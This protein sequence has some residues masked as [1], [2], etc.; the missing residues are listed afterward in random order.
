MTKKEYLDWVA[1]IKCKLPAF[2]KSMQGSKRKGF[3][4]YSYSGDLYGENIKW[5]LGNSVF[6][7]KIYYSLNYTPDNL[8]E[9]ISFIKSF[10]QTNGEFFDPIVKFT[11]FPMRLY[12]SIK[13]RD[14]NRL[15]H[16]LIRMAESRQSISALRL[17]NHL[18]SYEYINY[19]NTSKSIKQFI[20]SLNWSIPWG[21]GAQISGLLF[22]LAASS[23]KNRVEL[24]DEVIKIVNTYQQKDGFWYKGNP[25][26]AQKVNG[27]MKILTGLN[28]AAFLTKLDINVL[29][30]SHNEKLIDLS[31]V[32]TNDAHAC[33]NF[34]LVYVL[35]HASN[36]LNN[37]YRFD[38]IEDFIKKRLDIYREYYYP[39]YGAFSF[40]KGRTNQHYYSAFISKGKKEPDIHGTV[41]FLWGL[42]IIG[43]LWNT[44]SITRL[45]E[46]LT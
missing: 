37:N 3:Y 42:S 2:M 8:T 27:S 16:Q 23:I 39:D 6:A 31:L 32:A 18:P 30:D 34:N 46:F 25:T 14:K 21:A 15:S 20:S 5:G 35:S 17:F 40:N 9:I 36:Q 1:E 41:M 11:S 24:I 38:E 13:E 10:Q 45:R 33:D 29:Q 4:R 26:L 7:L 28:A 12:F 43:N 19:P 44:N 22:L